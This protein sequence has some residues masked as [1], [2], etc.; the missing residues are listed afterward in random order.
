MGTEPWDAEEIDFDDANI[1]H[2]GRHSVSPSEIVAVFNNDP[3]W[4][5]N[6]KGMAATHLMIGRTNGG[7]PLVIAV[8][9]DQDRSSLRPITGR[10]CT[11]SEISRWN[12]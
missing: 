9:Y 10:T 11:V 2:F 12:V 5:P 1:E 3:L 4:A 8:I 7:R 6:K